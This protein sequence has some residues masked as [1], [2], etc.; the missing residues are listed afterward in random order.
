MLEQCRE[1]QGTSGDDE[2]DGKYE[3]AAPD[4]FLYPFFV[5]VM[6]SWTMGL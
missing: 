3:V 6:A 2:H 1:A 4:F 5:C